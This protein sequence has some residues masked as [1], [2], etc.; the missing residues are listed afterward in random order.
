MAETSKGM[1][2]TGW[3][4]SALPCLMLGSGAVNAIFI[5]SQQVID[6]TTHMGYPLSTLTVLGAVELFCV[7]LYLIP[8]TAVLG[9]ILMTAYFGG[10]V[11]SHIR[12]GESI[13]FVPVLFGVVV[14]LGL[15]LRDTRLRALLPLS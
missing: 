6:G 10:A 8:R 13:W 15:W 1:Y 4:L 2:W 14:W 11:A 12:I 9:A 7:I 5:K 3:V